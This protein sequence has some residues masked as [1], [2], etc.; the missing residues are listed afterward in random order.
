[1]S[2]TS[3]SSSETEMSA[4]VLLPGLSESGATWSDWVSVVLAATVSVGGA[5]GGGIE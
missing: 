3:A 2:S 5:E 4:V 1:M